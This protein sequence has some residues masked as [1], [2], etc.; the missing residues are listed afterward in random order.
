MDSPVVAAEGAVLRR[1][2]VHEDDPLGTSLD[3]N[4]V[5]IEIAVD[6]MRA[7]MEFFQRRADGPER[8]RQLRLRKILQRRGPA[9]TVCKGFQ[10]SR[11]S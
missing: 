1:R 2:E 3:Q 10:P 6:P 5:E 8:S 9:A 7:P 4:I 11:N